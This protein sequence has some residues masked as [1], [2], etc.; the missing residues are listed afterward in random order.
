MLPDPRRRNHAVSQGQSGDSP[1][2][3]RVAL[4]AF[5]FLGP[6]VVEPST[7]DH[8]DRQ[9]I[10]SY[11][12]PAFWPLESYWSSKLRCCGLP[13]VRP[14]NDLQSNLQYSLL[15]RAGPRVFTKGILPR[16]FNFA[17]IYTHL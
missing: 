14:L 7:Q 5:L 17:L 3:R 11:D 15:F 13:R 4:R 6:L 10:C 8:A 9:C 16:L 1:V 2:T 12:G